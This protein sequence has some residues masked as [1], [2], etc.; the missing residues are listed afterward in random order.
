MKKKDYLKPLSKSAT[1]MEVEMPFCKSVVVDSTKTTDV[2][3]SR[4]EGDE[5]GTPSVK[6]VWDD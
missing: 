1:A 4:G 5:W 2:V 3:L 6:S